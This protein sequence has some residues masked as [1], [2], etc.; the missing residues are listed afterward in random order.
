M[1]G[2]LLGQII[3]KPSRESFSLDVRLVRW[4]GLSFVLRHIFIVPITTEVDKTLVVLSLGDQRPLVDLL[5]WFSG[6]FV[7]KLVVVRGKLCKM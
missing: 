1:Y 7:N 3:V 6:D 2:R 5:F 4:A